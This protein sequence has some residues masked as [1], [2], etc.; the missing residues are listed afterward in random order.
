MDAISGIDLI[1][2]NRDKNLQPITRGH[3]LT[4]CLAGVVD[5]I[6][7]F[8][9]FLCHNAND[10]D[11]RMILELLFFLMNAFAVHVNAQDFHRGF[12]LTGKFV[13]SLVK[14]QEDSACFSRKIEA[15]V[16]NVRLE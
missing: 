9:F 11:T 13:H 10:H 7:D 15:E 3:N 6:S 12:D 5:Q 14:L 1:A 8:Y 4:D 2:G 16:R